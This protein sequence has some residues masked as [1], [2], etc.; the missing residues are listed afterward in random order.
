[1]VK[2]ASEYDV[3][4]KFLNDHYAQQGVVATIREIKKF[5]GD[6]G[7]NQTYAAYRDRWLDEKANATDVAGSFIFLRSVVEDG[8]QL[9]T[10]A[11]TVAE[12]RLAE[13]QSHQG[14][15]PTS[16]PGSSGPNGAM[17]TISSASAHES[18]AAAPLTAEP[19]APTQDGSPAEGS[20]VV[21]ETLIRRT[22]ENL[23]ARFQDDAGPHHG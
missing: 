17:A 13:A 12:I 9:I 22:S 3:A 6:A 15:T 19:A 16:M 14:G 2:R 18:A 1:M 5:C 7:S 11:M 8:F 4:R 21:L 10:R 20:S 23:A